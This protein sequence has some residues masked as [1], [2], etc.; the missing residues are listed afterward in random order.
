MGLIYA[1]LRVVPYEWRGYERA[2]SLLPAVYIFGIVG[3]DR[4]SSLYNSRSVCSESCKKGTKIASN[5]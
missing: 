5:D 1:T 3:S 4:N 2:D